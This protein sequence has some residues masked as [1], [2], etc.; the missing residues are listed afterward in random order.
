MK[1]LRV[2]LMGWRAQGMSDVVFDELAL[3]ETFG[4]QVVNVGLTHYSRTVDRIASSDVET[5]WSELKPTFDTSDITDDVAHYGVRSYLAMKKLA[6]EES[7]NAIT[8]ECFH[9][10]LGGPCLGCSTLNDEGIASACESDVPGAVLMA[11]L[12]TLTGE[13]TF[14]A[15]FITAQL[16]ENSV[17]AGH[18][19]NIPRRVSA[20]PE[21]L[22]LEGIRE[23]VG[24]GAYG[25]TIQATM[26]PG[27]V[28]AANLVG[29]HG[30][31]RV[32]SLEGEA[33]PYEL[34]FSGSW[35]KIAFPFDITDALEQLGNAG[36]GHHFVIARGHVGAE[37]AEWCNLLE[38]DHLQV[39][40]NA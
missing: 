22:K 18:C 1:G 20:N 35:S 28:T 3:S 14:H 13:P 26:K 32:A 12:Q 9:D 17:V 15:D 7:L 6:V 8:V 40:A 11:A 19:G 5:L 29:R 39:N 27:P 2:G 4:V 16:S 24:P 10:H 30:T 25:P 36:Y 37:L 38:I 31:M 21:I 33:I 23:D 34:E